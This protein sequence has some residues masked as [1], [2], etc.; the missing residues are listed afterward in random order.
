MRFVGV[1]LVVRFVGVVG[2]VGF[3][4]AAPD[5]HRYMR[6]ISD[7]ASRIVTVRSQARQDRLNP[8]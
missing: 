7:I 1:V 6:R 3:V 8:I 5:I 2:F 4:D